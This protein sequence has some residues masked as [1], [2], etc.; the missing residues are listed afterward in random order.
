M[1]RSSMISYRSTLFIATAM[2]ECMYVYT[3]QGFLLHPYV[4]MVGGKV[5]R[6]L[7]H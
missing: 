1:S 7:H 3:Q 4:D 5:H 6:L 2:N